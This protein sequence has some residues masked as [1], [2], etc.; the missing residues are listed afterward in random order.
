[1]AIPFSNGSGH[2]LVRIDIEYEWKPPRCAL[3]KFFDHNDAACPKN[4]KQSSVKSIVDEEGFV[5]ATKRKGKGK[6][7]TH[8]KVID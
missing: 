2:S 4:V 8:E 6:A 3:C 1:M 5:E 7:P